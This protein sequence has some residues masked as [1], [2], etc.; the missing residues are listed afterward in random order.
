MPRGGKRVGA[1]RKPTTRNVKKTAAD[2]I[3]ARAEAG[4]KTP[5]EIMLEAMDVAYKEGG[6]IIAFPFAQSCAP[7]MHP[8]MG[9]VE[10]TGKDG[11]PVQSTVG[12]VEEFKEA[13]KQVLGMI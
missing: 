3:L 8:K 2:A 1:G 13:A 9:S 4:G 5:I 12:T 6:A 11:G 7:F 10:V